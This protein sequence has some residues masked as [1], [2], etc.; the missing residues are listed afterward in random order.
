MNPT[1]PE[2]KSPCSFRAVR[3]QGHNVL[4]G[5]SAVLG[6]DNS[7]F[8]I[9]RGPKGLI[10]G[11]LFEI[12]KENI[13]SIINIG[14]FDFL[15]TDRTKIKSPEQFEK[16]KRTVVE[17][18]LDGLVVIGR[19]FQHECGIHCGVPG[20][21]GDRLQRDRNPQNDRWRHG[22]REVSAHFVRL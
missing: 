4:A 17:N 22:G 19:R 14:G 9:R 13:R 7:L 2:D 3:R 12:S 15:G 5:L 18:R 20:G 16:V 8:G 6:N 1:D 11:D 21:R 10:K